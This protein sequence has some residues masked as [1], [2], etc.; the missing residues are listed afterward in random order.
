[1]RPQPRKWTNYTD[2]TVS[3]QYVKDMTLTE[4][5]KAMGALMFLTEKRDKS[6]KG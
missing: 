6:V 4:R 5:R 3:R 2:E 1:M